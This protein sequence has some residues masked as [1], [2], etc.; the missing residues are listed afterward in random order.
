M[1][2]RQLV[3]DASAGI[4]LFVR[5]EHSGAIEGLLSDETLVLHV[6]DLFF[7]ECTNVL[8]KKVTRGG[9]DVRD[10]M[11][12][13]SKMGALAPQVTSTGQLALAAFQIA[14]TLGISAYDACYVAL[15]AS[16]SITLVTADNRLA[17]KL[18]ETSHQVIELGEL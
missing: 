1:S 16:L 3:L 9:Y 5:E 18:R 12:A 10:A 4:K 11:R 8:W 17:N 6:P 14:D 13:I 7:I 2:K 15:A